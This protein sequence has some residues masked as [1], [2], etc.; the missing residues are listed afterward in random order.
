MT[1][2][3]LLIGLVASALLAR[4]L[5]SF[6][7]DVGTTDALTYACVAIFLSLVAALATWV[8]ATRASAVDPASVLRSGG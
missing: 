7:Y 5:G 2:A 8:P 4:L 1:G 6:L 3:G